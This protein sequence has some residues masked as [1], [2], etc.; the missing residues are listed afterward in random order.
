[1][2][3]NPGIRSHPSYK[4]VTE[5]L[6]SE[7]DLMKQIKEMSLYEVNKSTRKLSASV[8][9]NSPPPK[10]I[11][12]TSRT[13]ISTASPSSLI[14][15]S[16]LHAQLTHNNDDIDL[17]IAIEKSKHE[18]KYEDPILLSIIE[19]SKKESELCLL[20]AKNEELDLLAGIEQSQ[21]DYDKTRRESIQHS[22]R[23][24]INNISNTRSPRA[25]FTYDIEQE[26]IQR[27]INQTKPR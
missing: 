27:A 24:N 21:V 10:P 5:G 9:N 1:M 16:P 3:L 4:L 15:A 8:I 25:S 14:S 6:L 19:R 23:H 11:K 18:I 22:V 2:S 13:S 7:E 12:P 20:K 17:Q 26:L